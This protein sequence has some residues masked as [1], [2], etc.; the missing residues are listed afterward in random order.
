MTSVR[1]AAFDLFRERGMTTIFGNPG[2]TELP[3]LGRLPEDFRYVLGLQEAVAVGMADGYAQASGRRH[4]R[5][6]AHRARASATRSAA[7]FNAQANKSP[8]LITAGQQVRPQIT[9]QANLTNRDARRVPQP[10]RQVEPR[11]AAG[12]GRARRPRAG[13]PPRDA[14]AA[15][16]RRSCRS[17]WTTGGATTSRDYATAIARRVERPRRARPAADRGPSP[18][19]LARRPQRPVL[20]AGPDID[21]AGGW[22]AAVALAESQRLPV[23]ATPRDR[24][25]RA[26]ASPRTTRAFQGVL[27]P[28]VGPLGADAR[29]PRPGA[30]RRLLGVPLLPLHPRPRCWPRAPSWWRSPAIPTRPPAR[31]WA[32]RSSADVALDAAR[33]LEL[34]PASR[35][36]GARRPRRAAAGRA[37]RGERPARPPGGAVAVSGARRAVPAGRRSRARVR[38]PRTPALRNQLR[39]RDPGLLLLR[40]PAAASASGSRRRSA[41]SSPSPSARSCACSARAR[42]STRSPRSGPPPPTEIPVKFLVLRNDEYSI[43]KWFAPME[44][45]NGRAGA[46]PAAASTSPRPPRATACPRS[47]SQDAMQLRAALARRARRRTARGSSRSTVAPGMALVYEGPVA[48]APDTRR[49]GRPPGGPRRRPRARQPRRR[50]ARAAAGELEALLGADRVLARA[51]R[52]DPLRLRRQPVPAAARGGRH[53]RTTSTTS[54][55]CC[56]MRASGHAGQLPRR[57]HEPQRPGPDRRDPDRRRAA[58][59]PASRIE[60]GGARVARQARHP[61]R[62][63]RT[64]CS[65]AT[66]TGSA[67]TRRAKTSPRSA[68]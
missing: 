23:W 64:G 57:R 46:R 4:A 40:A 12:A 49:I 18:Q 9:M 8:L 44:S 7:I 39:S 52:P 55:A 31:R 34:A 41:S 50:H 66:A 24:R 19:R 36:R 56:A 30:R 13:D 25:R 11:A 20:V 28:A 65:P 58:G 60:D 6:P 27:P 10:Y 63:S 2:S 26:S 37:A 48:A 33:L 5:Q 61:A 47:R 62:A 29:R 38:R 22:D 45:V 51:H 35:R 16:A 42:R 68:A 43:L 21:A 14:A 1:D 54:R 3:M 15:A 32:T 17:R 53:G 59:S 67:P